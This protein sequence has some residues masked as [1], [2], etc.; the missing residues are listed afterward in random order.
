MSSLLEQNLNTNN[1]TT[2]LEKAFATAQNLLWNFSLS[3][4]FNTD[5]RYIFGHQIQDTTAQA[6][7]Q[8]L[9]R[10]R[11]FSLE[12][13]AQSQINNALGAYAQQTNTIY[14]SQEFIAENINNYQA[15]AAVLLEETGHYIDSQLNRVDTPGDEGELFAAIIQG[16]TLDTATQNRIAQE[17]DQ[18]TV[19]IDGQEIQI[20]QAT[21]G[22]NPAFDLIGLTQLRNDPQFAGI[23]G[24]GLTAV[25]IDTG[26]DRN[27]PLLQPHYRTGVDF[28]NGGDNPVDNEGHGTHV[29]GTV[30]AV[31][32]NIGVAPQVGLIGLQVFQNGGGASNSD[33][34]EAL[35]WVYN[36][37]Q[38]YNIVVVNM[39]LGSGFYSSPN[40]VQGDIL[41]D[42]IR[43]LEEI[44]VTVVSAGGNS[45]KNNEY[46]NYGAPAI[47]STLAVGA[48]WQDGVNQGVSFGSGAIDY[49]TG[50]DRVTSFS[51]RLVANN[52]IFDLGLLLIALIQGEDKIT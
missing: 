43:R 31:D 11:A 2:T 24:S 20:E 49:T 39:S 16:Q 8:A 46:Q 10:Q 30:G 34:E 22:V 50:T 21:P 33:I 13:V 32:E 47:Y 44:G 29:S 48:V 25:V 37:R 38:Q 28:V 42:D 14:L 4:D 18:Y 36:N 9:T 23:D 51:Q 27:H 12:I 17:D 3:G 7:F 1:S 40:Q 26:L 41:S 5:L 52:T 15:I 6:I 35:E 19:N 45:F